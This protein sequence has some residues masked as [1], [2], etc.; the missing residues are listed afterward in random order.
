MIFSVQETQGNKHD[1]HEG[2]THEKWC[3]KHSVKTCLKV[4]EVVVLSLVLLHIIGLFTIP[5][6]YYALPSELELE[7]SKHAL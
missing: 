4:A 6:V 3:D 7:V 2:E 1:H 5:T